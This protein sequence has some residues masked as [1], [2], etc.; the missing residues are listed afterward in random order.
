MI[1]PRT[2]LEPTLSYFKV[3]GTLSMGC[4]DRTVKLPTRIHPVPKIRTNGSTFFLYLSLP[5]LRH[6]HEKKKLNFKVTGTLSMGCDG[7]TVKLPTRIHPVPKTRINGSTF[8]VPL[9]VS[10]TVSTRKK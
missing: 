7:R 8:F 9:F 10:F 3:T 5:L 2:S 6:Q 4:D 1:T